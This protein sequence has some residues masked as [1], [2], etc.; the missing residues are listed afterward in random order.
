MFCGAANQPGAPNAA[1]ALGWLWILRNTVPASRTSSSP[2]WSEHVTVPL[3]AFAKILASRRRTC[4]YSPARGLCGIRSAS[5]PAE[6]SR[7]LN[8][9]GER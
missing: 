3:A 7:N 9:L 8:P 6:R 2:A 5:T 4:E 1:A